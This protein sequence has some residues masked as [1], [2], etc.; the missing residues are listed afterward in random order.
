MMCCDVMP[1]EMNEFTKKVS[2]T[3]LKNTTG[4]V[5]K[6]TMS[7]SVCFFGVFFFFFFFFCCCC[8]FVI[9]VVVFCCCFF[10]VL[11]CFYLQSITTTRAYL[12]LVYSCN[13]R[14][15]RIQGSLK[16]GTRLYITGLFATIEG[17]VSNLQRFISLEEIN[18]YRHLRNSIFILIRNSCISLLRM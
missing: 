18:I 5:K 15:S 11:F 10:V 7:D 4:F 16:A 17:K 12:R 2:S 14:Q 8:C 1:H 3:L 9:V 13:C 6:I